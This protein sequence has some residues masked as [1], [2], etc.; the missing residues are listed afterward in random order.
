MDGGFNLRGKPV[1]LQTGRVKAESILDPIMDPFP[2]AWAQI[3]PEPESN[4]R[5]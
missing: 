1:E 5:M 2:I 3:R 4:I